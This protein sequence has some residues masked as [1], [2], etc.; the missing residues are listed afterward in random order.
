MN[1]LFY[2]RA[3]GAAVAILLCI[4]H[5]QAEKLTLTGSSTLAP[6][7]TELAKRF[8]AANPG[9]EIAV[10]GGGS[11][12]G[13][14]DA[15]SGKADIGMVSRALHPGE[16]NLFVFTI[17]RDGIALV[18]HGSNPVK[19]LSRAQVIDI[20]SGKTVNWKAVGGNDAPINVGSRKPGH[21][22]IEI[23]THY[24]SLAPEAIKQ[25]HVVGDNAEALQMLLADPNLLTF[26]SVGLAEN[27][28]HKGQPV[29]TL[30]VEGVAA[31]SATVRNGS[32]P[33]ARPL[34]LVTRG[35]PKG[36]ARAFIEFVRSPHARELIA[37][38]DFVP[39]G[40]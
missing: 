4:P 34:N 11:S 1:L 2:L 16:K 22:S 38:Y 27:S 21:A 33:L 30:P 25:Q 32:Y 7:V 3:L 10:E 37:E 8:M 40:Y 14:A 24:F 18:V 29:N 5:A 12:R 35:V 23:V 26:F 6:M 36:A 13:A 28:L 19:S 17:A 31:T 20:L 39:Y 15:L 9:V